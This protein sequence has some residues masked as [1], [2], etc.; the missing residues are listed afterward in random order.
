MEEIRLFVIVKGIFHV[1]D[2]LKLFLSFKYGL[3]VLKRY[4]TDSVLF[5]LTLLAHSI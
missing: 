5:L 2:N 1:S 4:S 3:S